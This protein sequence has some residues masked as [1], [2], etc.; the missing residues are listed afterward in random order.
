MKFLNQEKR[1]QLLNER[2]SCK[3]FDKHYTFSSEELEEIAEIARLSP[4][5]YNTQPWHFVMVTNKDLKNQ[6][7]AHSYF[8]KDM[9][10]SASALV[11]VCS[12]KP[13]ELLPNGHYMQNLY[14]EPYRSRTLLSFAQMLDLRFNHSM[15]KLES[16][17]LEQCYIAVGQICLGV[18][19][20]GLD[21]CIIGGFD[22]LKVGEVLS[23]RINDPKIA[24]LI[25]L[26]KRVKEASQKS[27]KP[28]NH[29]ITWL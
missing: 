8:N 27:R 28:K 23:Q 16:Y 26:G 29:A 4:S 5:S 2:H 7:A 25:A 10:E 1:K 19:L 20:M 12:L 3:M 13:V 24:C 22:A 15:Q 6:I 21:S 18:S 11:V 17:I 9:I 14:D